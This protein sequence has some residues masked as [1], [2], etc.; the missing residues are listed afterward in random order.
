MLNVVGMRTEERKPI[1]YII[2]SILCTVVVATVQMKYPTLLPETLDDLLVGSLSAW[3]VCVLWLVYEHLDK[4]TQQKWREKRTI[5][6]IGM[7]LCGIG[8]LYFTISYFFPGKTVRQ[9]VAANISS[10]PAKNPTVAPQPLFVECRIARRPI[11]MPPSGR[12]NVA[13]IGLGD[14]NVERLLTVGLG[15]D[16]G[17]PG[18]IWTRGENDGFGH[19]TMYRCAV[20]NYNEHPIFNVSIPMIVTF[21]EVVANGNQRTYGKEIISASREVPIPRISVGEDKSYIFYFHN[22]S[23][24]WISIAI[25]DHA[26]YSDFGEGG[27]LTVPVR[28]D[29]ILPIIMDCAAGMTTNPPAATPPSQAQRE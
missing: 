25:E 22:L 28:Q 5:S 4:D 18:E 9:E 13:S 6:L 19:N 29:N 20:T 11:V 2:L 1:A 14:P 21:H 12:I 24:F 27:P 17:Q 7:S 15:E 10:Q 16:A 23:Q 26:I 3:V 8:F